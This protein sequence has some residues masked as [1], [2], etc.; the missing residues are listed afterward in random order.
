[1][2][3]VNLQDMVHPSVKLLGVSEQGVQLGPAG[4]IRLDEGGLGR[5]RVGGRHD[6]GVDDGSADGEQEG[7]GSETDA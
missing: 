6:V 5:G 4:N 2:D 3:G 1:M 7:H